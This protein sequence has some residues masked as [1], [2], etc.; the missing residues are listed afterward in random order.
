MIQTIM[1]QNAQPK[2]PLI[3]NVLL[4]LM[5][6]LVSRTLGAMS[7][8]KDKIEKRIDYKTNRSDFMSYVSR[9]NDEKGMSRKEIN[10]IFNLLMI[11]GSETTATLLAGCAYLLQKYP[12][13][14][15]K[16]EDEIRG[17]FPNDE[18][19]TMITV[20]HL[21]YLDAVI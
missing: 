15:R 11:A 19:I 18:D 3:S 4:M 10:A 1:A 14:L 16:L 21:K 8:I 17:P 13:V 20:G 2:V 7:Y 6:P 12:R 9:Y 5:V